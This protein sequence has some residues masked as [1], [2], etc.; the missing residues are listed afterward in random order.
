M[1]QGCTGGVPVQMVVHVHYLCSRNSIYIYMIKIKSKK[2]AASGTKREGSVAL[3]QEEMIKKDQE[4]LDRMVARA[5][6][7]RFPLYEA[8]RCTVGFLGGMVGNIIGD[9]ITDLLRGH[10]REMQGAIA[11]SIAIYVFFREIDLTGV[12]H[13]DDELLEIFEIFDTITF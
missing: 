11:D 2:S 9:R 1:Y 13:V 5:L 6:A 7:R 10:T 3:G 4:T 12:K 8:G